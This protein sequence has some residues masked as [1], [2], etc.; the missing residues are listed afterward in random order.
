[1]NRITCEQLER[2]EKL[3]SII[4]FPNTSYYTVWTGPVPTSDTVKMAIMNRVLFYLKTEIPVEEILAN[5]EDKYNKII[6]FQKSCQE[7][8]ERDKKSKKN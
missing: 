7:E 2:L 6:E 3:I 5:L 8:F 1:M 4:E